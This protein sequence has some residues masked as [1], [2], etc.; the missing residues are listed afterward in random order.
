MNN[1]GATHSIRFKLAIPTAEYEALYRGEA[2]DVQVR[3]IDN[4]IVRFPG[5]AI[6]KFLTHEGIYGTFTIYFDDAGKL[7]SIERVVAD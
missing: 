4:R 5:S 7:I 2:R 3:A 6:T 1:K